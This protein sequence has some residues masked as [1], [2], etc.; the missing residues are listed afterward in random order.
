[1]KELIL[2][3]GTYYKKLYFDEEYYKENNV[4]DCSLHIKGAGM[5]LTTISWSDAGFDKAPDDKGIKLGTFRS[6]TMF[7][8]GKEAVIEDL[9]IENTAGDGRIRGQAVA[10]Y[11][12]ASK[13]TCRRVHLKGHQDTLF[14]S[15]LPLTER[16]KG[17]FIGP[18]EDSPR[19]MTTQYY[20]DCIIEG[21]VDFIFGGANATFKNCT[22][23][24]LY[25]APLIDKNTISKEKA[26]DYTGVPIQGF[27]CAPCT[28]ENE[29]GMKFIDCKFITD[30]C[31]DASVYLA[32]PWR[33]NGG[34]YFENCYFG[35]HIHPDLFAGWKD[36]HKIEPTARFR[37]L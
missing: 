8:S 19:L 31:P 1:M 35:T 3:K 26:A 7:V 12:D 14:M 36:V 29:P 5:D 6:Y 30:R 15:P 27:V 9:T 37:N 24:S 22:I 28:P 32:R 21:D 13:V 34:A 23:V 4:S 16:E 25:R 33:E 10:L 18:R 11:A 20:E 17:G 2:D